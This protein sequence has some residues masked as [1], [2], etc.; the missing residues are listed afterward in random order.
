MPSIKPKK[1]S[2]KKPMPKPPA[3]G[4]KLGATDPNI[5]RS[6]SRNVAYGKVTHKKGEKV[7]ERAMNRSARHA[8]ANVTALEKKRGRKL[9]PTERKRVATK[10]ATRTAGRINKR[11]AR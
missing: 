9:T 1:P 7:I 11:R 4:M 6:T 10:S 5:V 3:K 8:R 2:S